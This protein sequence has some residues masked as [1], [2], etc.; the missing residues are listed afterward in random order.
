MIMG[1]YKNRATHPPVLKNLGLASWLNCHL[2]NNVNTPWS[3]GLQYIVFTHLKPGNSLCRILVS[4]QKTMKYNNP[5][6]HFGVPTLTTLLSSHCSNSNKYFNFHSLH[7]LSDSLRIKTKKSL[8]FLKV[9]EKLEYTIPFMCNRSFNI[10]CHHFS[11]GFC[12]F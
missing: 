9:L 10:S 11:N 4:S 5:F 3:L 1:L 12:I 8:Y 6:C 7:H 2:G